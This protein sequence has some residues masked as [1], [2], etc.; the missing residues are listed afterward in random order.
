MS[1]ATWA[2]AAL[3]LTSAC[4]NALT[5]R[6]E[7]VQPARVPVRAFPRILVVAGDGPESVLIARRL[8]NHLA[9]SESTVR[10]VPAGAIDELRR[11]GRIEP[12]TVIVHVRLELTRRDRT[13]WAR[14]NSLSCGPLGCVQTNRNILQAVPVLSGRLIMTVLDGPSG[15]SL[16]R[17]LVSDEES[18]PD[19]LAMRMRVIQRLT[20]RALE[21][22]DQRTEH[23]SVE[24]RSIDH[25]A[26]REALGAIRTGGWTRGRRM[27]ERFVGS[28]GFD[29]LTVEQRALVLYDLGQARRF[30]RSVPA[31]ERFRRAAEALRRAV[32]LAP[33]SRYASALSELQAHRRSRRMVREQEEATAHN[34]R[35]AENPGARPVPDPPASYRGGS[36]DARS[37]N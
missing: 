18:G 33:Q 2:L 20:Q 6:G 3:V 14:R 34:F 22:V 37:T 27:L 16:Q 12:A 19:V 35:V 31:D 17:E 28:S 23:V 1:R 13:G 15:R 32:R 21:L 24:L 26:V 11:A 36:W 9:Q 25:P 4:S 29:A 8:A 10:R 5:V 7:V 30:D